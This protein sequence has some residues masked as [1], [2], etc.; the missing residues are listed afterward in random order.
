MRERCAVNLHKP[1]DQRWAPKL[2]QWRYFLVYTRP[3]AQTPKMMHGFRTKTL[4]VSDEKNMAD[5][6]LH[7]FRVLRGGEEV[8]SEVGAVADELTEQA[9]G[10]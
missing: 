9:S 4:K 10:L 8:K 6:R 1:V 7:L 2:S 3:K 5:M